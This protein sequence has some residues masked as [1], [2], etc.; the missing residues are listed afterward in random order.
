[1]LLHTKTT[2]SFACE[3]AC[4]ASHADGQSC[5]RLAGLHDAVA[6]SGAEG[7]PKSI[8]TAPLIPA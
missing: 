1:V 3:A 2:C 5:T 6:V 4:T 8:T 7:A